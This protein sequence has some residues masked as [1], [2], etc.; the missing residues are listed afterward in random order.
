MKGFYEY[1]NNTMLLIAIEIINSV[2]TGL[3]G[4]YKKLK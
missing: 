2:T 4:R 3:L 1:I